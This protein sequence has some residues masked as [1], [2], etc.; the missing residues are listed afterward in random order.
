LDPTQF[1]KTNGSVSKQ[2]I[3]IFTCIRFLTYSYQRAFF[4]V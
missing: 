3:V 2:G 4:I 1:I